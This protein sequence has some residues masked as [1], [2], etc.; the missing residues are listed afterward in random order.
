MNDFDSLTA[1]LI[2]Q[3]TDI[4]NTSQKKIE[5][6]FITESI[7]E[8]IK[9]VSKPII[10]KQQNSSLTLFDT[11]SFQKELRDRSIKKNK[12]YALYSENITAYDIA[13]C[14]GPIGQV[15]FDES[16]QHF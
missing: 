6:P 8:P 2:L 10:K 4:E 7:P 12:S 5:N 14:L 16:G 3:Q 15:R 1:G 9:Q 11:A 13:S